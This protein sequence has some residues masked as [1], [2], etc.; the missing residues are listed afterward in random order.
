MDLKLQ[1]ICPQRQEM[2]CR[3]VS[4]FPR[5]PYGKWGKADYLRKDLDLFFIDCYFLPVIATKGK[6]RISA[7]I[8]LWTTFHCIC[9]ELEKFNTEEK[10]HVLGF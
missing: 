2:S 7:L 9:Y 1:A 6:F 10:K 5:F 8:F 4:G 3:Q